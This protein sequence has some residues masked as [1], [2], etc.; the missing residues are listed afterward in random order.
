MIRKII[1]MTLLGV[2]LFL[3]GQPFATAKTFEPITITESD[4]PWTISF[5]AEVDFN[6]ATKDDITLTSATGEELN[7]TYSISEDLKNITVKPLQPYTFG[8]TYTLVVSKNVKSMEGKQLA[9]NASIQF[10]LQGN[11]IQNITTQLS[12]WVTNVKVQGNRSVS[13]MTVS[14]NGGPEEVLLVSSN[15]LFQRGFLG[16]AAG[17]PLTIRAYNSLGEIIETQNYVIK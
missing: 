5:N 17:D 15:Y 2:I 8:T 6:Q 3:N 14:F 9:S 10:T 7:L 12:S 13:K 1:T 11:Y 4:K 16:L